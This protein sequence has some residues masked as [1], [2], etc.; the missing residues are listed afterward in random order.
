MHNF[1][2][3]M[4]P[5]C[6]IIGVEEKGHYFLLCYMYDDIR[7]RLLNGVNAILL[8]H[9]M[10]NLSNDELV[11]ILLYGHESPAP[12]VRPRQSSNIQDWLTRE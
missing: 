6:P 5:L 3:T 12:P 11:N 7:H 2:D 1:S 10:G 4:T 8:P 9:V